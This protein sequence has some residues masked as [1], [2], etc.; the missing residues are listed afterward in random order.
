MNSI[1][2]REKADCKAYV[3][4]SRIGSKVYRYVVSDLFLKTE[5]ANYPEQNI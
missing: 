3:I 5:M 1:E 2:T 4:L